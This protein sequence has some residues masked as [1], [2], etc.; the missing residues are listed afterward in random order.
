MKQDVREV[1]VAGRDRGAPASGVPARG[2][3]RGT[4]SPLWVFWLLFAINVANYVDRLLVVAVGPT[5]KAEF[6]LHDRA[7]GTLSSAFLLVYTFAALPVGLL[8]DRVGRARV[9]AVGVALWSATSMATAAVRGY[10]GLLATRAGVGIGEASY[11]PAGTALLSAYFPR[12]QRARALSRWGS[13]QAVGSALAFALAA[14]LYRWLGP[15]VG[16]RVAFLLTGA[17]GLALAVLVWRVRE[18]PAPTPD[19]ARAAGADGADPAG[20]RAGR[21]MGARPGPASGA[22]PGSPVVRFASPG[23]DGAPPARALRG[24]LVARRA[25]AIGRV[26]RGRAGQAPPPRAARPAPPGSA[27]GPTERAGGAGRGVV[28]GAVVRVR[29][30]LGIPTVRLCIA[31][32]ALNYVVVTPTIVFLPIYLRSS[33]APFRVGPAQASLLSG[34]ILVIGGMIGSLLGGNFADWMDARVHGGRMLAVALAYGAAAPCYALTLLTRSLPL[35]AVAGTLTVLALNLLAG[36]LGAAVQDVTPARLRATAVA[37]GMLLAHLLG[38]AWAPT[39]VG[40]LSTAHGERSALALLAVGLP[41]LLL[42]AGLGLA[43]GARCYAAD[44][45]TRRCEEAAPAGA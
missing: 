41:A 1:P 43:F 45:G 7:I 31:L 26:W 40:A 6:H 18:G 8:A 21:V 27:A 30:V 9:V 38:D 10:L 22:A 19:P 13:G 35:F 15:T 5:L 29:A 42:A 11:F 28:G 36:P 17:P 16:W 24:S 44:L 2:R 32:Q 23:T 3:R 14:M 25:R 39:A 20:A 33:Q 12:E 37:V 4:T 34:A